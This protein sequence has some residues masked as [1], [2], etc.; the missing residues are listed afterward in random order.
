MRW[1]LGTLS[2]GL[3]ATVLPLA[4][5][6]DDQP[7]TGPEPTDISIAPS[8]PPS[9]ATPKGPATKP[10]VA[11]SEQVTTA[12]E[13]VAAAEAVVPDS[14]AVEVSKDDDSELTWEVALRAG[15]NGTRIW[16]LSVDAG[17]GT[18]WQL[19]V[20]ASSGSVLRKERD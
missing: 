4:A 9:S 12:V 15:E 8:A 2:A 17:G 10:S 3:L 13:A 1:R 14:A 6:G 11:Q 7:A 16:D 5:C 18:E 19:W 20:D